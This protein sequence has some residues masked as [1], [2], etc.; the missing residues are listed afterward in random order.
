MDWSVDPSL[1]SA[2]CFASTQWSLVV[3]AG[4]R[5]DPATDAALATL[6]ERYWYPLYAYARRRVADI[7][8]AQDLTQGFFTQLLEQNLVERAAPERGR[9][10]SFLLTSF[11]NF[12]AN[13][14]DRER[15][16]KRGGTAKRLS[17]DF[18]SG[19]S[20]FSL[21][22]SHA[23]TAER[24]YERQWTLT[25]LDIAIDRLRQEHAAADTSDQFQ[26]LLPAITSAGER[27]G[28]GTIAEKLG[29]S[30]QAARQAGHR[31][32]SRYR[33]LLREEVAQTV[34]ES[35]NIDEEIQRLFASLQE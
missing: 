28:Y 6:C 25:L 20:R 34:D 31:L 11:Q 26:L 4:N 12:M 27:V 23:L 5:Q 18:A 13:Q 15:A 2:R 32:R 17:L 24:L 3:R 8:E 30:E 16:E 7:N 33:E 9:F 19:D 14:W 29:I 21:E 35:M 22:P 1:N 10:R